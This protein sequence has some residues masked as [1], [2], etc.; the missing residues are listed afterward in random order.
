MWVLN[1][2]ISSVLLILLWCLLHTVWACAN[3]EASRLGLWVRGPIMQGSVY[4]YSLHDHHRTK[5]NKIKLICK[6][7]QHHNNCL[8]KRFIYLKPGFTQLTMRL[9]TDWRKSLWDKYFGDNCLSITVPN[10]LTGNISRPMNVLVSCDSP[11]DWPS[12]TNKVP[13]WKGR[14]V[15]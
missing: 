5:K 3:K 2:A 6:V 11:T 15:L 7:N 13:G 4:I 8:I 9:L 14:P 1:S 12:D 10:A